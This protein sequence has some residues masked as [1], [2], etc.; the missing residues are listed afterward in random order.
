MFSLI[1]NVISLILWIVLGVPIYLFLCYC[2]ASFCQA[3]FGGPIWLWMTIMI[4]FGIGAAV[5]KYQQPLI[6]Q[7]NQ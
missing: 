4:I 7:S 1:H 2:G 5:E 6:N 3:C